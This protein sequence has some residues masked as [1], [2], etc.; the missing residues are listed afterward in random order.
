MK[1]TAELKREKIVAI[2]RG[3]TREQADFVGE[4]LTKAEFGSWK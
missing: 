1:L 2:V 3:I 4:G